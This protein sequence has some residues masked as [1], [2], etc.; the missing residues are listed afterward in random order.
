MNLI[1]QGLLQALGDRLLDSL[2]D[3]A[4]AC[5]VALSASGTRV[6]D[7]VGD[8][9]L[10]ASRELLL[11]FVRDDGTAG[12]VG[13]VSHGGFEDGLINSRLKGFSCNGRYFGYMWDW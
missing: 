11:G 12:G 3:F 1:R 4:V 10:D 9:L 8:V 7:L 13:L 2:G 6:V 5:G